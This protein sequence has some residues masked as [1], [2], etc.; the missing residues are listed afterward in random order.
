MPG[1][2]PIILTDILLELILHIA[3]FVFFLLFNSSGDC[4]PHCCADDNNIL[5]V[6]ALHFIVPSGGSIK[7]QKAAHVVVVTDTA[8]AA[9]G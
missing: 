2:N 7:P 1:R 9:A 5:C 4:D 3:S 6:Y 8:N